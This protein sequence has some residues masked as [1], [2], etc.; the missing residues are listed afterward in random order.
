[1]KNLCVCRIIS[2]LICFGLLLG[3]VQSFGNQNGVGRLKKWKL[4]C[5]EGEDQLGRVRLNHEIASEILRF[6]ASGGDFNPTGACVKKEVLL[7]SK[8]PLQDELPVEEIPN[9][10]DFYKDLVVTEGPS[11]DY[12]KANFVLKKNNSRMSFTFYR[13]KGHDQVFGCG[14]LR[15]Y[16]ILE[17]GPASIKLPIRSGCIQ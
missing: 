10:S 13:H 12:Y 9:E 8:F 4:V 6:I 2:F 14:S 11:S 17:R 1:M 7:I 5:Q 15:S 3:S 16:P